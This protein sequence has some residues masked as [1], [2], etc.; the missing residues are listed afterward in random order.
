MPL[1]KRTP[2]IGKHTSSNHY[3]RGSM[4]HVNVPQIHREAFSALK[5]KVHFWLSDIRANNYIFCVCDFDPAYRCRL[6]ITSWKA[7]NIWSVVDLE[8]EIECQ[9][10]VATA[11]SWCW[12]CG[13]S[14]VECGEIWVWNQ[15]TDLHLTAA[16]VR[17]GMQQWNETKW[18]QSRKEKKKHMNLT[19]NL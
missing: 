10:S 17:K 13:P 16:A 4:Q 2:E 6:E 7:L 18:W 9:K 1:G 15:G 3:S 8:K 14:A 19:W 11:F 12:K 5:T